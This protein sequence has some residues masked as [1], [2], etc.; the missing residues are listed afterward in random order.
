MRLANFYLNAFTLVGYR[1][2]KLFFLPN[3]SLY[4]LTLRNSAKSHIIFKF[5]P[6]VITAI[7]IYTNDL[8]G[9]DIDG[10][11]A[12]ILKPLSGFTYTVQVQ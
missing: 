3:K 5:G 6:P 2:N 7:F 11:R 9:G 12:C 10:F 8:K 4:F 1:N